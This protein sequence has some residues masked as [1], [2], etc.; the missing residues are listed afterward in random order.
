MGPCRLVRG[1]VLSLREETYVEAARSVGASDMRIMLVHLIPGVV[2]YLI[3]AATFGIAGGI[4]A[5]ASLGFLGLGV[6]PPDASWG[7]MVNAALDFSVLVS[8]P[9]IWIPPATA[10]SLAVLS[11]NFVG[12]G[13]R[14]AFDPK[15]LD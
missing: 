5:E 8:L 15:A 9:W 13:L 11:I 10:I 2:P 7:N 12:D 6:Q 4:M 14:D 1:Q 3:V